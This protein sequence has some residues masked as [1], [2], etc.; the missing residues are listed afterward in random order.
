MPTDR[1][2]IP[3]RI[4]LMGPFRV[5]IDGREVAAEEWPTRRAAEL[6]Q[7]LALADGRR[8]AREQVIDALWPTLAPEAG[9]ANLRKAAHHARRILGDADSVVLRGGRVAL[10]P[11]RPVQ[12]DVE[13]FERTARAAFAGPDT[14]TCAAAVDAYGGE[15]LPEARYEEWTQ[16][17]REQLRAS[18]LELLRRAGRWEQVVEDDPTDEPAC[19][20]LMQ[21]ALESG[22]RPAAI[23]WFGRLRAALRRELG[24]PPSAETLELF[25]RCAAGLERPDPE[26]VGRDLELA[27]IDALVLEAAGRTLVLR[28]PGGIGKSALCRATVD[29][30]RDAG[31]VTV[32]GVAADAGEPYAPLAVIVEQLVANDAALLECV[33]PRARSVLGRLASLPAG[34]EAP[35]EPVPLTRHSVTG[36]LGRLLRAGGGGAPVLL[37]ID[38]AHLADEATI[39]VLAHLGTVS[40]AAQL[41]VLAYRPAPAPPALVRVAERLARAGLGTLLDL[42]A[43]ER[44]EVAELV[45]ASTAVPRG[46]DTLERIFELGQGNPFLTLELAR[47]AVAG[48]AAL[49]PT[50][51][52]AITARFLD[53]DGDTLATLRRL[54]L[55]GGNLDPAGIVTL[56]GLPEAQAYAQLDRA[57]TDG[58]LIVDGAGY[59]F[60][61]ELVRQALAD[62]VA[63]HHRLAI[64]RETAARLADGGAPPALIARQW[65][66]G[67]RPD[68]AGRW[69][70]EAARRAVALGAFADALV[71]LAPLLE[72]APEHPEAL[73]LRAEALDAI[74]DAEAPAAY[75]AAA[76]VDGG[77]RAD[78]LRAKGALARIKLGDAPGGLALVDGLHPITL[79]GRVAHALAYAGAAALG[80]GDPAVGTAKA[81][82]ARRLAREAGDTAQIAIASWAQAAA[83]HAR[84]ELRASVIADLND[85]AALPQIALTTFDGQ[86]CITQRL[87]YGARPYDDVIAFADA[88]AIESERLGAARGLA[89]AVTIRGEA[90]LLAGRLDG[91]EADLAEGETLHRRIGAATGE[92]FALQRHAEVMLHR[93]EHAQAV[94]LLDEALDIA[95]ES[96]VGFHLFDRIYGTRIAMATDPASGLAALEEAEEAVRGPIETCPGCRIT[97]A[98]PAVIAAARG[99]DLDRA[100]R[101][102]PVA[103]YLTD[104]VMRLPAWYAALDEARGHVAQATGDRPAAHRRFA[105]AAEAFASAGHPL[106]HTRCAALAAATV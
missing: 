41:M 81:A 20:E 90:K 44:D 70:L 75:K 4:A 48:V 69:L 34:G 101:W 85:T 78:D 72:H 32:T 13:V 106:D 36:A 27:R 93:G 9:A 54:A 89:F 50:S 39:D 28:G 74:G 57:L 58:V 16:A 66:A 18:H 51:R 22:N 104:V 61:H 105:A 87:L 33:G 60:G 24:V 31:W 55:A 43:L 21:H 15:L 86:L 5:A 65:L 77:P 11:G 3:V 84:G 102:M 63:P 40:G 6:V 14:G 76:E 80:F 99:G 8:L 29:A 79:E 37:V 23:R 67:Q 100:A 91:A 35:A 56:T 1:A 68:E 49:V 96:A 26:L 88:L 12:T 7:L 64:H 17:P 53:L 98:M 59:R 47:S 52:A 62:S 30:A 95:R 97:L 2:A 46:S 10:F 25:G 73:A 71:Q 38:D 45:A 83:A 92:A 42:R 82:E 94:E 19:R 103:E